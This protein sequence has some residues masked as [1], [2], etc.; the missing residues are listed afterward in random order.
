MRETGNK[1]TG[2]NPV[3]AAEIEQVD[4]N[5]GRIINKLEELDLDKNT[6]II[7]TSDNGGVSEWTSNLPLRAGKGT[8]YEGGIRV[9]F[10]VKWP[11]LVKP[12][13][14]TDV[15]V[16]TV[17]NNVILPPQNGYRLEPRNHE[18]MK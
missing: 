5:V 2:Q 9:P 12:G 7:F 18:S 11:G 3:Y 13:T 17:L 15:P 4:L 14:E 8:F 6:V 10:C 16:P 1:N